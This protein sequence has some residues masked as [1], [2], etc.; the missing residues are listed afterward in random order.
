MNDY[1]KIK[2]YI[3]TL[4]ERIEY[5][6]YHYKHSPEANKQIE[7]ELHIL[8]LIKEKMEEIENDK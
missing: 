3:N 7:H 5:S 8:R 4:N 2:N 6:K 1:E